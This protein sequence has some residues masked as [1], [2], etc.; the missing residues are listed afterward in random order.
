MSWKCPEC[1]SKRLTVMVEVTAELTQYGEGDDYNFETTTDS[2]DHQWDENSAMTCCDCDHC[3]IAD[4]FDIESIAAKAPASQCRHGD[5]AGGVCLDCKVDT[6]AGECDCGFD[7]AD[8]N[9]HE[10][11]CAMIQ[12][13]AARLVGKLGAGGAS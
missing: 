3:A 11:W 4:E 1:G 8:E 7:P 13:D 10:D 5:T 2:S 6:T 9:D 12:R